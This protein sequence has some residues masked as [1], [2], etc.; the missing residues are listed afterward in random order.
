MP[1]SEQLLRRLPKTDLHVHLD[2][3]MRLPTVLELARDQGVELPAHDLPGLRAA[4]HI[5]EISGS[6]V[7]YL[8]AFDV[9]LQV[10][11][12]RDALYRAA[13]ELAEDAAAEN[14]R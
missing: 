2:G 9:T 6:L 10:L 13:Y 8:Q 4:M 3:S 5:G 11:Q 14:V 7:K 12:T 1:L